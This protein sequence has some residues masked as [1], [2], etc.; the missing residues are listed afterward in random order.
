MRLYINLDNNAFV[1]GADNLTA[2]AAVTMKRGDTPLIEV[3]FVRAGSVVELDSGTTGKFGLKAKGDYDGSY[4]VSAMGWAKNGTGSSTIYTFSPSL[5]TTALNT[6][7]EN[8][9]TPLASVALMGEIERT[10]G[11]SI[12]STETI[13]VTIYNDVNRGEEGVP[14]DATPSYPIPGDLLQKGYAGVVT[15]VSGQKDYTVDISAHALS[16]APQG[17]LL[18]HIVT[19]ASESGIAAT[20]PADGLTS[21][22]FTFHLTATP[23]VAGQKFLYLLLPS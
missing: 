6:L 11:A 3:Q 22:T 21:S 14:T 1:R 13:N 4:V 18:Q 20:V 2:A 17:V 16:S 19:T 10:L 9:G 5:N 8:S 23:T 7:L 15:L 12:T